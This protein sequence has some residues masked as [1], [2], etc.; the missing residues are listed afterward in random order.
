MRIPSLSFLL[1]ASVAAL[2]N[3]SIAQTSQ[4][5]SMQNQAC[6]HV[7]EM[8]IRFS[9]TEE[10]DRLMVQ[11]IGDRCEQ[12]YLAVTISN[13]EDDVLYSHGFPALLASY[14]CGSMEDCARWVFG[15]ALVPAYTFSEL[16]L[17]P[18]EQALQDDLYFD[19][20]R[21]AYAYAQEEDRPLYC[22]QF[23]KSTEDCMVFM[24]GKSVRTHSYGT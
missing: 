10:D 21:D 8:P 2:V 20:N 1:V 22:F 15:R 5:D 18:L 16:D 4:V 23:G 13:A 24:K 17:P 9:S 6:S 3:G 7:G 14:D 19:V 12:P 11:I